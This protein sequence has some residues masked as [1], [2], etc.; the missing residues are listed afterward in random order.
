VHAAADRDQ[1][2]RLILLLLLAGCSK[3]AGLDNLSV[4]DGGEGGIP[5]SSDDAGD[6]ATD[7]P[8]FKTIRCASATCSAQQ[9][10][11]IDDAGAGTCRIRP[12]DG[13][14]ACDGPPELHCDDQTDCPPNQ[15]CC[16]GSDQGRIFLAVCMIASE[17]ARFSGMPAC[18]EGSPCPAT[19]TCTSTGD[20]IMTCR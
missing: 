6:A 1:D 16:A 2:V 20:V 8:V 7:A 13:G 15:I 10:C 4:S 14:V 3:V 11:C 17:C 12:E 19:T 5:I 18:V 9:A